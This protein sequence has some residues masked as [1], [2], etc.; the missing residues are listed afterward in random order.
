LGE[1]GEEKRTDSLALWFLGGALL[2]SFYLAWN[3]GANDLAN[4]MGTSVGSKALTVKQAVIWAAILNLLGAI[5]VGSRVTETVRKNI[6]DLD[7]IGG[8]SELSWTILYGLL[9][10]MLAAAFWITIATYYALPVSTTHAIVGAVMGFGLVVGGTAVVNWAVMGKIAASWVV[11]PLA[12]A[13]VAFFAFWLMKRAI[14]GHE[15][16]FEQALKYAPWLVGIVFGI[17][18]IA[19]IIEGLEGLHLGLSGI[20]IV[21]LGALVGVAASIPAYF[22]FHRYKAVEKDEYE[23]VERIFVF[24]QIIT[25]GYVAFA[26]GSNDVANAIGPVSGIVGQLAYGS[27]NELP[28]FTIIGLLLLGGVGIAIGTATWGRQVMKTIGE[29]ITEITPTRG[30][31]AEFGAATTV[32]VCSLMGLPI[33]TTHVLVG[34][35]IGVGLAGGIAAVDA[36]VIQ[37][38]VVSWVVTVPVAAVTCA[39]IYLG[40]TFVA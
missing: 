38:I 7:A 19:M 33:S 14:L 8:G 17:L 35:V 28:L 36:K 21:G 39:L 15:R 27:P 3:I 29:K 22:L 24:L 26:H 9:A 32:L 6:I 30:F 4:A 40:I 37:K 16:P 18:A 5:I 31:T 20:Q 12:G 11:S 13:A 25:A 23:K 34:S 2:V 1:A 10:A